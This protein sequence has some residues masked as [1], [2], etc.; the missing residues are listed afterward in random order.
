VE[1]VQEQGA[2]GRPPG[3]L[4]DKQLKQ[5]LRELAAG[6]GRARGLVT[7]R[8]PLVELKDW[9]N[10]GYR[11]TRCDG[12]TAQGGTPQPRE[13]N[14]FVCYSHK[15][16]SFVQRLLARFDD[17]GIAYWI[18]QKDLLVGQEID[19]T[20]SRAIQ[21]HALFLLVLSRTSVESPWVRRELDEAA[22]EG[23][24]GRKLLL[25][26]VMEGLPLDEVPPRV[27]RFVCADFNQ[28]FD[29]PY[30]YLKRSIEQHL[31]SMGQ[32]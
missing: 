22:H 8:L 9:M 14:V 6:L 24:E 13:S 18:D 20:I 19:G 11:E 25:P 2:A 7:S 5:L 21:R 29:V 12:P 27:R 1:Q 23:V 4:H 10:R 17:D 31:H 3:E 15:D 32:V 26:V 30:A 16:S 28:G